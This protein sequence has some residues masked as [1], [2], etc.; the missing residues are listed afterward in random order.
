[1]TKE[2]GSLCQVI[3]WHHWYCIWLFRSY[4]QSNQG[5]ISIQRNWRDQAQEVVSRKFHH[6]YQ[7]FYWPKICS[8]F[9]IRFRSNH[10]LR[11]QMN[12]LNKWWGKFRFIWTIEIGLVLWFEHSKS[13]YQVLVYQGWISL[14]EHLWSFCCT[15]SH[16]Q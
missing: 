4:Q 13:W 14:Q 5:P 1:M 12:W 6:Y 11:S 9:S 7:I 16:L 2:S 10:R 3:L 8:R 15:Y